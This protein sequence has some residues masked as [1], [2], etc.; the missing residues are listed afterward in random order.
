[1]HSRETTMSLV[2]F[3]EAESVSP[4]EIISKP[5]AVAI[6]AIW[7]EMLSAALMPFCN[8]SEFTATF[9]GKL[10]FGTFGSD[11]PVVSTRFIRRV[12]FPTLIT[13]RFLS[14]SWERVI[15]SP[16]RDNRRTSLIL[17]RSMP[18]SVS[19]AANSSKALL[20]IFRSTM[21]TCAGSTAFRE[22]PLAFTLNLASSTSVETTSTIPFNVSDFT[23][24]WN[25]GSPSPAITACGLI[26]IAS[27]MNMA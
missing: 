2:S 6:N 1:M 22:T 14:S 16:A 15:I 27:T 11:M 17:S 8:S 3:N 9:A 23:L 12:T 21:A 20:S 5:S 7:S 13:N 25:I 24:A 26:R 10:M 4:S 19:S 18:S